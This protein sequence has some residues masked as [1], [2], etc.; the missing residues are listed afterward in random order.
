[1]STMD[2]MRRADTPAETGWERQAL[3]RAAAGVL[4]IDAGRIVY[5]NAQASALLGRPRSVLLGLETASLLPADALPRHRAALSSVVDR[6]GTAYNEYHLQ[7][8]M[9]RTW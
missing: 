2:W 6:G 3:E 5:A 4:L 7:R 8:P 1:M 9:A